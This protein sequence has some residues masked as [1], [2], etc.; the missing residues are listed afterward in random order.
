MEASNSASSHHPTQRN[1]MTDLSL[2]KG[3]ALVDLQYEHTVDTMGTKDTAAAIVDGAAV[4]KFTLKPVSENQRI[5]EDYLHSHALLAVQLTDEY[6]TRRFGEFCNRH[7]GEITSG[8]RLKI[9]SKGKKFKF[10]VGQWDYQRRGFLLLKN[11]KRLERN[12]KNV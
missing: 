8:I 12:S 1:D 10:H 3:F 4:L 9:L 7:S 2:R 5:D 6:V 11:L